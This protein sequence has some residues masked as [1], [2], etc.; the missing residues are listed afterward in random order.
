M[1]KE[2]VWLITLGLEYKQKKTRGTHLVS[3]TCS[4]SRSIQIQYCIALKK[5]DVHLAERG[6]RKD[7]FWN[8]LLRSPGCLGIL[9]LFRGNT[10]VSMVHNENDQR[11]FMD[12]FTI[13]KIQSYIYLDAIKSLLRFLFSNNNNN[14]KL[15]NIHAYYLLFVIKWELHKS[16]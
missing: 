8:D 4:Y 9:I 6:M 11:R 3:F 5:K 13:I 12:S 15:D 7:E 14:K 16:I 1:N 10:V 2:S